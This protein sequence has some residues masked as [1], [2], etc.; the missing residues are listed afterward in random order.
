M[1]K[2]FASSLSLRLLGIFVVTAALI[3]S[4]LIALF[5]SGLSGQWRRSIQPH[6][7][8]YV[9]YV[10]Q[11]LGSP[12]QAERAE[13]IAAQ[14]PVDIYI[15][16]NQ[17]FLYSTT[18]KPLAL[19]TLR[20]RQV[21]H[22]LL[23]QSGLAANLQGTRVAVS[24]KGR[25][26]DHILRIEEPGY[27][28]YYD[29]HR[30]KPA[31]SRHERYTD[32]LLVALIALGLVLI[33]SYLLI[34]K[35]VSPIRSI[36]KSVRLM[37]LGDLA[38]RIDSKGH[39]DLD[40]LAQSI[41]SMAAKLQAMLDAKR[42]LLIALSHELRSP[43]TRARVTSELLP[44]TTYKARLLED[45][46][47][48]QRMIADIMES[49]QLQNNHS[50]LNVSRFDAA[51]L[52]SDELESLASDVHL[53]IINSDDSTSM[54]GDTTRLRIMLRNLVTNALQHGK[55]SDGTS[56]IAVL[57]T[58]AP[59]RIEL[60]VNDEGPGIDSDHLQ[61]ISDPF[62]RPDPSRSRSTGGFGLGLTLARLIA[63]AHAGTLTIDSDAS[64][65]PGTR[66]KVTLP[67]SAPLS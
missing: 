6:L 60:E 29:I 40:V 39:S 61:G 49:E 9:R 37:A 31:N 25:A 15:Y 21:D 45:L 50:V 2:T 46:E 44:E 56:R 67:R 38:H 42:Q 22:R 55:S 59:E 66:I 5:F 63:E 65:R 7:V 33:A 8:Q 11:D 34:R 52:F 18:D 64:R 4:I 23:K 57:L 36:Q 3:I 26:N 14:I 10:Q 30:R 24:G 17:Q 51:V 19:D 16:A 58:A 28:V 54:E 1:I 27:T 35:A 47:E 62:Y 48:M 41:D 43:L 53:Q 13:S 12:P 32:E 20:F